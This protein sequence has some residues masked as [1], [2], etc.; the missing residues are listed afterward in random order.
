MTKGIALA[1]VLAVATASPALAQDLQFTLINDSGV[2]IVAFHVSHSNSQYWEQD[3]L[4]SSI[5]ADGHQ[6]DV[7]ISDGLRTCIYD[8][9]TEFAD[10]DAHEDFG[11]DLCALG[12]YTFE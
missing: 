3:L 10:G 1:A 7:V 8:I 6:V 12:S 5:L 11:V 9:R 4:G 2:D